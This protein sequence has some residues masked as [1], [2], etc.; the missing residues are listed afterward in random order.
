[1]EFDMRNEIFQH[2]QKL[3]FSFFN[4][5]KTGQLMSRVTNDLFDISE[6]FHHGPEDIV[7]SAIKLLGSFT[8][9]FMINSRLAFIAFAVTPFIIFYAI[10]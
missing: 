6:L 7:I 2:Y 10:P 1:M 9:L 8:I 3:S 4:S 5:Q